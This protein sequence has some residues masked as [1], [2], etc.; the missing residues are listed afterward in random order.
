[1]ELTSQIDARWNEEQSGNFYSNWPDCLYSPYSPIDLDP[2]GG[3]DYMQW[4]E[5]PQPGLPSLWFEAPASMSAEQ[6]E[7][8]V[9]WIMDAAACDPAATTLPPESAARGYI[10]D[11]L[12]NIRRHPST[13]R[14][15]VD[16]R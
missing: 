6:S 12:R 10:A 13:R 15:R 11:D 9:D 7:I 5:P 14:R 3:W 1:M 2:D 16:A 4:R 8:I